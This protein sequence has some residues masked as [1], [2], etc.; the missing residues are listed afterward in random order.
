M[1]QISKKMCGHILYYYYLKIDDYNGQH[2][3]NFLQ[4]IFKFKTP[5]FPLATRPDNNMYLYT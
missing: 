4:V 3:V 1:L 5:T 2:C